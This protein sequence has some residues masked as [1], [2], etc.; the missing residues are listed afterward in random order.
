MS[1]KTGN[2]FKGSKIGPSKGHVSA[3]ASDLKNLREGFID[4]GEIPNYL[5]GQI[6]Q[7]LYKWGI[8]E[9]TYSLVGAV[10]KS[11]E[12]LIFRPLVIFKGEARVLLLREENSSSLLIKVQDLSASNYFSS[13]KIY[14]A[15][16]SKT[17]FVREFVSNTLG[18]VYRMSGGFALERLI[19]LLSSSLEGLSL[20]HAAGLSHCH[21]TEWNISAAIENQG[22]LLDGGVYEDYASMEDDISDFA[23]ICEKAL[24]SVRFNKEDLISKKKL[25]EILSPLLE[26][27]QEEDKSKRPN[28]DVVK[29]LFRDLVK[30]VLG[31]KD[32]ILLDLPAEDVVS[33]LNNI[34]QSQFS[35]DTE[36]MDLPDNNLNEE[37][38]NLKSSSMKNN[39]FYLLLLSLVLLSGYKVCERFG[40]F[41]ESVGNMLYQ[42]PY[43]TSEEMKLSWISG[44]PS[45]MKVVARQAIYESSSRESAEEVIISPILLDQN[46]VR[47][48]DASLIRVAFSK[49]WEGQLS[50]NDKRFVL[51]LALRELLKDEFPADLPSLSELHPAVVLAVLSSTE[52]KI[53][54]I[55]NSVPGN[56]LES[57]PEPFG[58]AFQI[59]NTGKTDVKASAEEVIALAHL[60]T[61]GVDDPVL[62]S[63]FLKN[64]FERRLTSLAVMYSTNNVE[65]LKVLDTILNHPNVALN[66]PPTE[67]AKK[68]D[69]LNWNAIDASDKLF[70][71]AG[72]ALRPDKELTTEQIA[73]LFLNPSPKVRGYAVGLSI[74]QIPFKHKGALEVLELVHKVPDIITSSQLTMLGQILEDPDRTVDAHIKV[75][76]NFIASEPPLE[77]AKT[78]LLTNASANM[79]SILD[80]SLSSYLNE[81][82]WQPEQA[83]LKILAS[84]HDKIAR[85]FAYQ[86]IFKIANRGE[87]LDLLKACMNKEADPELKKQL[88][89][90][91]EKLEVSSN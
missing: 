46:T 91:V 21:L 53:P 39:L 59:L 71:T 31:E 27:M 88:Q 40:L 54:T 81:K 72:V 75:V 1:T 45:K 37:I 36:V 16:D 58:V 35:V 56:V 63:K 5:Q 3:H 51:S 70:L 65:S 74:H 2:G 17:L 6:S 84:H 14:R 83:E 64:D 73:R 60:G 33:K 77:I 13:L 23:R 67:W 22:C 4:L 7:F 28:I 11:V 10:I 26:S 29:T 38:S 82:G 78:L 24:N 68:V 15:K 80:S 89:L 87:S 85:M 90:M 50:V 86:A 57:L 44:V 61:R 32:Q 66:I 55:L 12:P 76:K 25:Q 49:E 48:V 41:G 30:M 20:M 79:Q 34:E 8:E 62:L 69:I 9:G 52:G 19:S 18:D 47:L 43:L 42:G